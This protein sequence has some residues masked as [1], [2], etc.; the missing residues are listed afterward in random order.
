VLPGLPLSVKEKQMQTEVK[1]LAVLQ[2]GKVTAV[3]YAFVTV[4]MVPFI[5]YGMATGPKG[6][7]GGLPM[8][9][10]VI[11]YPLLGF[12]FGVLFAAL[13]NLTAKCIGGIR[14]TLEESE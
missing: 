8:L 1:R 10:I 13:Y 2:S 7:A 5:L 11:L 14:F 6:P 9:L 12:I 3:L 4:I